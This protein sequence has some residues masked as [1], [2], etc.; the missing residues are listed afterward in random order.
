[1]HTKLG[2][3]VMLILTCVSLNWYAGHRFSAGSWAW[4]WR[5]VRTRISGSTIRYGVDRGISTSSDRSNGRADTG[6]STASNSSNGR[7]NAG[8]DRTRLQRENANRAND[9]LNEHP[10]VPARLHTIANHLRTGYQA[11]LLT[12]PVFTFGQYVA[13]TRLAANLGQRFPRRHAV[14]DSRWV[15]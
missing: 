2:K 10:L 7:S 13:A 9:E 8:L 14:S 4:S 6:R 12:Q 3:V 1:M 5:R 11:A 15:G